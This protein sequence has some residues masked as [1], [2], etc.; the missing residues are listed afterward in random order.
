MAIK[1]LTVD[2]SSPDV[3]ALALCLL[4]V[5]IIFFDQR[6]DSLALARSA[7][8]TLTSPLVEVSTWPRVMLD[9]VGRTL[10]L[11]RDNRFLRE[12]MF[13]LQ[14]ENQKTVYL[15]AENVRLRALL[16]SARRVPGK[17]LP[18]EVMGIAPDTLHKTLVLD[19][20]SSEGVAPGQAVLDAHG[21]MGQVIEVG[22]FSS[23]VL[24]ITDVTHAT[25]VQVVRN[26]FRAILQGTG[27]D[28]RLLLQHASN[29]ADV[30]EGDTL[31]TS[32][33]G[34]RFPVGYPV[35]VVVSVLQDPATP[36][37]IIHARPEAELGRSHYLGIVTDQQEAPDVNQQQPV[38]DDEDDDAPAA[39]SA[40]A[41]AAP[42]E[43][44]D[45]E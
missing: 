4:S 36:F 34:G 8:L 12:R 13:A 24:L 14:I 18:A 22:L 16:G 21:L 27:D 28:S 9:G 38:A 5:A 11:S 44:E 25:P 10:K 7:L 30:R 15:E 17:V 41:L 33:L 2:R 45:A 23:R 37:S 3:K 20:G 42:Q 32:G 19:E 39:A 43:A 31:V 29:T 35:A 6:T 26:G 40:P 1:P